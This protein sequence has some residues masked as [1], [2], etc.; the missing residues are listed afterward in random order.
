V[1]ALV[2]GSVLG[3]VMSGVLVGVTSIDVPTIALATLLLA[4]VA[5]R[6]WSQP[7]A[8]RP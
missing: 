1:I 2:A 3:R 6:Q 5:L 8:P 4:M 7:G